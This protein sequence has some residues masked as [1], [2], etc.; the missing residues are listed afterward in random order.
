M[1][2]IMHVDSLSK[3]SSSD[4][5]DI[6]VNFHAPARN[7]RQ[8]TSNTVNVNANA[9]TDANAPSNTD[10]PSNAS[11]G[12]SNSNAGRIPILNFLNIEGTAI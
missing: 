9:P 7:V 2:D 5:D 10:E 4:D 6:L 8:R 3:S 12:R 11:R 1:R